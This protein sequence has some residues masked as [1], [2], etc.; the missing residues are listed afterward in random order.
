[1]I[2]D[3]ADEHP[4]QAIRDHALEP[5]QG[6]PDAAKFPNFVEGQANGLLNTVVR[7][8]LVAITSLY[9]ADWRSDDEFATAR[10]FS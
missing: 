10:A 9:K 3:I 7:V 2:A 5:R 4:C 6:L 1:M 8:L